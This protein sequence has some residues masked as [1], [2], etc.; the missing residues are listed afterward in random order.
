MRSQVLP[1]TTH[2]IDAKLCR[3][4]RPA[5]RGCESIAR[6]I[7]SAGIRPL[8]LVIDARDARAGDAPAIVAG[9]LCRRRNDQGD[10]AAP[11]RVIMSPVP[12][13][14]LSSPASVVAV[15]CFVNRLSMCRSG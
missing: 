3:V 13:A 10:G 9:H 1:G 8:E 7:V 6:P 12:G 14:H 4:A 11:R 15:M 2:V 5:G